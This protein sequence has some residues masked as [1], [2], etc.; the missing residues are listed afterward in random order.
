MNSHSGVGLGDEALDARV[1]L[2]QEPEVEVKLEPGA[3]AECVVCRTRAEDAQ[4]LRGA[5]TPRAGTALPAFLA[6]YAC[7]GGLKNG[8]RAV[9]AACLHLVDVLEQAELEYLRLRDAFEALLRR[10]PLFA[11]LAPASASASA[12]SHVKCELSPDHDSED[13][14]LARAKK[15]RG[16]KGGKKRKKETSSGKKRKNSISNKHRCCGRSLHL[17]SYIATS[18]TL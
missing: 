12:P 4:A 5:R 6:R 3:P 8:S 17:G 14:P 1:K 11:P 18:A 16:P 10:N 7:V 2:E 15:K 9:C 13:E